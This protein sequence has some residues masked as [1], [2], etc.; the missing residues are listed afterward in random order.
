MKAESDSTLLSVVLVVASLTTTRRLLLVRRTT[1]D[2]VSLSPSE[3]L[4]WTGGR[5]APP[6]SSSFPPVFPGPPAAELVQ[7]VPVVVQVW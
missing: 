4:V 6:A 1:F 3:L 2:L 7:P 5:S